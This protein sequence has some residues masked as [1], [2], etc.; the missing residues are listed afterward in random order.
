MCADDCRLT[1]ERWLV[2]LDIL[3]A[4]LFVPRAIG[5]GKPAS[6]SAVGG[7]GLKMNAAY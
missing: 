4:I 5:I 7:K 1:I 2:A 6:S 3:A